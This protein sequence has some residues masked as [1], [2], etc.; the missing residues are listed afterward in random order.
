MALD[1][2]IHNGFVWS[3]DANAWLVAGLDGTAIVP[4]SGGGGG[5]DLDTTPVAALGSTLEQPM[6]NWLAGAPC[7]DI[8]DDV[9]I[10]PEHRG[11]WVHMLNDVGSIIY[12]PDDWP[13]GMAFGARQM[14]TGPC[15]WGVMGG[16]TVQLPFT[17]AAHTGIT[18][19]YEEVVF[20]VVSNDD[21]VS[22]VWG[23]SGGTS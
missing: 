14:G 20:R 19:Q 8:A 18:E 11:A 6:P 22:A 21:G 15:S 13:A 2:E 12:L 17:K 1:G 5:D 3:D 9:V 23:V 4:P 16:A 7:I 10:T